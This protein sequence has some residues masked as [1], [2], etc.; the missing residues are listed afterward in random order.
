MQLRGN[1][2]D[3]QP[4]AAPSSST[5]NFHYVHRIASQGIQWLFGCLPCVKGHH[6]VH[7]TLI[8]LSDA[9]YIAID[10]KKRIRVL[11]IVPD[12]DTSNSSG[13][14]NVVDQ[15]DSGDRCSLDSSGE[16][17]WFMRWNRPI[18][19][20]LQR[21]SCSCSFRKSQTPLS[22][23]KALKSNGNNNDSTAA[24]EIE[25]RKIFP[26]SLFK[27][28]QDEGLFNLAEK[29]TQDILEEAVQISSE[30]KTS[31]KAPRKELTDV[32]IID[33]ENFS[34][35][36]DSVCVEDINLGEEDSKVEFGG[37]VN[38]VFIASNDALDLIPSNA[39]QNDSCDTKNNLRAAVNAVDSYQDYNANDQNQQIVAERNAR[40][41]HSLTPPK[42]GNSEKKKHRKSC[43]SSLKIH[44][45]V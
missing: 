22:D 26:E 29:L 18:R 6:Q 32:S 1:L 5:G 10:G 4:P 16:D 31:L 15:I 34:R 41:K 17:Y 13:K 25:S 7:P 33:K 8:E 3:M 43:L 20:N 36:C 24:H 45:K 30:I 2:E 35:C 9:L 12:S 40:N 19:R 39:T 28:S 27:T 21:N 14:A 42:D 11:H 37:Y 23:L 38:P 44:L